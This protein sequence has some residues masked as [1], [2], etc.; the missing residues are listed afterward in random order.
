MQLSAVLTARQGN[1]KILNSD[2]GHSLMQ[3]VGI[4]NAQY[5][6]A[7][8]IFF[9]SYTLFET[10]SNYMLK[11]FRPSRWI[12]FLM[13]AWGAMTMILGGIHNFGALVAV[14]FLLGM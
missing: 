7:L 4:T 10:P 11:R 3:N 1:A 13:F 2:A 14:R 12:A 6:T 9:V 8:M 5:L